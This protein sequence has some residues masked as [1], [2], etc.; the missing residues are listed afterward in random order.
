V[1]FASIYKIYWYLIRSNAGKSTG[2]TMNY[3]FLLI[4]HVLEIRSTQLHSCTVASNRISHT[5]RMRIVDS[6][7]CFRSV[8]A[9]KCG[10]LLSL[11]PLNQPELWQI[12]VNET[13][14]KLPQ[15]TPKWK[16]FATRGGWSNAN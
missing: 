10:S 7:A 9:T 14:A 13:D 3:E 16:G 8:Q 4:R 11:K 1:Y 5:S 12:S 2:A 15:V 6:R